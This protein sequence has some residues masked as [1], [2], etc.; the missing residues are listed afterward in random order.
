VNLASVGGRS[1][2]LTANG[3]L[4]R[5]APAGRFIHGGGEKYPL[6]PAS[7][8]NAWGCANEFVVNI[9][10][11]LARDGAKLAALKMLKLFRIRHLQVTVRGI[12]CIC[13][14]T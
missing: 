7:E 1:G 2:F 11:L 8:K 5:E 9:A 4:F 12:L 10:G 14:C 3:R 13:C 6:P